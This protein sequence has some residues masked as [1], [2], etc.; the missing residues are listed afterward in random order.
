M[1]RVDVVET[2]VELQR[3]SLESRREASLTQVKVVHS[4]AA[5]D[6]EAATKFVEENYPVLSEVDK[7]AQKNLPSGS[8][9]SEDI[10]IPEMHQR[11]IKTA[12][13]LDRTNPLPK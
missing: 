10:S 3:K 2:F 6:S 5:A 9:L 7:E 12:T 1:R 13:E 11:L 8:W 4:R